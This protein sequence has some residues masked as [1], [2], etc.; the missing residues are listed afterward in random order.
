MAFEEIE[1]TVMEVKLKEED[2]MGF[3]ESMEDF[4]ET[5]N[6]MADTMNNVFG[7]RGEDGQLERGSLKWML[8]VS[9][10]L[11]TFEASDWDATLEESSRTIIPI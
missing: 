3:F 2:E 6:E 5:I 10:I 11:D 4:T 1:K 9:F 7:S 8:L